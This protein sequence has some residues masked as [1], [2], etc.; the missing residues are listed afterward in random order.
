M[1]NIKNSGIKIPETV[2]SEFRISETIFPETILPSF[3]ESTPLFLNIPKSD[4]GLKMLYLHKILT[5]LADFF[6]NWSL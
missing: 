1:V 3:L 5:N 6:L 2:F 4:E